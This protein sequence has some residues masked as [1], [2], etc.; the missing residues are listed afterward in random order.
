M[1]QVGCS[2]G[3]VLKQTVVT[4]ICGIYS[5]GKTTLMR[6][7]AGLDVDYDGHIQY[8]RTVDR[9]LVEAALYPSEYN[10]RKST[11]RSQPRLIGWCPQHDSLFNQLTVYEHFELFAEL[12]GPALG[13][14]YFDL[15]GGDNSRWRFS[16][17]RRERGF[18][19]IVNSLGLS[20]HRS[21]G[22]YALSGGMKRR[23]SL[24]LASMGNPTLLILD[25]PTSGC[26]SHTRCFLPYLM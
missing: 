24:A 21:K 19:R 6:I 9:S 26:D 2:T 10:H 20:D 23:L 15:I 18:N 11:T 14:E 3:A 4:I 13:G 7:I 12:L 8:P 25:E 5:S 17:S 16:L 22:A 1:E